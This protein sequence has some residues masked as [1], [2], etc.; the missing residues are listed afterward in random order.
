MPTTT[1]TKDH[2]HNMTT[3]DQSSTYFMIGDQP[4]Q[5]RG[6]CPRCSSFQDLGEK[7]FSGST[8]VNG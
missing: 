1:T 4:L 6:H 7:M 2:G 8:I 3:G 5:P